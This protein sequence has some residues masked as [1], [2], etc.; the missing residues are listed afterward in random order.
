MRNEPLTLNNI[1]GLNRELVTALD[2]LFP[3]LCPDIQD[4]ERGIWMYA[5]KRQLVRHLKTV[6]ERQE[7]SMNEDTKSSIALGGRSQADRLAGL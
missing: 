3:E 4:I 7:H 5:G 6:L 1:P 2:T